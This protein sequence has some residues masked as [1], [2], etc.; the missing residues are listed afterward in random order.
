MLDSGKFHF[1]VYSGEVLSFLRKGIAAFSLNPLFSRSSFSR[2][3]LALEKAKEG[4]RRQLGFLGVHRHDAGAVSHPT[5]SPSDYTLDRLAGFR[6]LLQRWLRHLLLHFKTPGP[7]PFFLRNG[8]V[9]ISGHQ[10]V[11]KSRFEIASSFLPAAI[12]FANEKNFDQRNGLPKTESAVY[13]VLRKV[14]AKPFPLWRINI[15]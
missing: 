15:P 13:Y 2:I 10:F 11:D 12:G 5:A 9:S 7:L 4:C 14:A 8:F 3:C 1:F 6:M